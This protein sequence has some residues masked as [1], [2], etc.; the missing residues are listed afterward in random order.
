MNL[1][2]FLMPVRLCR[3]QRKLLQPEGD[4]AR[5]SEKA[6]WREDVP[7]SVSGFMELCVSDPPPWIAIRDHS[8]SFYFFYCPALSPRSPSSIP[9][10]KVRELRLRTCVFVCMSALVFM[11]EWC[12][13]A[14]FAVSAVRSSR[15]YCPKCS[16]NNHRTI[17]SAP[18]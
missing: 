9:L 17:Q 3:T 12:A 13:T 11:Y 18:Q 4:R 8:F 14:H 10:M 16:H 5:E 1:N 2:T 6:E 15:S 7:R